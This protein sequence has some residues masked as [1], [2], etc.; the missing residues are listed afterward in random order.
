[1]LTQFFNYFFSSTQ[2]LN[3]TES[4]IESCYTALRRLDTEDVSLTLDETD[5]ISQALSNLGRY[6]GFEN[7]DHISEYI[8]RSF[9]TNRLPH[10]DL[11]QF[12]GNNFQMQ[13]E[14]SVTGSN[15]TFGTAEST[16]NIIWELIS[17]GENSYEL[18]T[19]KP[20]FIVWTPEEGIFSNGDV[21]D[22][23]NAE[24]MNNNSYL[25]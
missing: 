16:A 18:T 8:S 22:V 25:A 19:S 10:E 2:Y 20:M 13:T 3:L 1:M 7:M 12:T 5:Q 6:Y 15:F 9:V 24:V 21:D 14:I 17:S 4:E 23:K 11:H